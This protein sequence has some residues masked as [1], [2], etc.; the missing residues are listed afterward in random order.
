MYVLK[1]KNYVDMDDVDDYIY[2]NNLYHLSEYLNQQKFDYDAM[3]QDIKNKN[4][5]NILSFIKHKYGVYEMN[6][7]YKYFNIETPTYL[8][9]LFIE[10]IKEIKNKNRWIIQSEYDKLDNSLKTVLNKLNVSIKYINQYQWKIQQEEWIKF[11]SLKT[12]EELN[13]PDFV[14]KLKN[15]SKCIVYP[16]LNRSSASRPDR[17]SVGIKMKH[18]SSSRV[19]LEWSYLLNEVNYVY[20]PTQHTFNKG[21]YH[22][23]ASIVNSEL[24]H[25]TYLTLFIFIKD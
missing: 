9:T 25:L 17:L 22:G 24:N 16:I 7:F 12:G 10:T 19:I 8:F 2:D 15:G 11:T 4:Q 23:V 3:E 18:L 6:K 1:N 13:G 20:G 21:G 5:S 14:I